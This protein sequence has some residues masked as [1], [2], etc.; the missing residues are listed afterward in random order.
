MGVYRFASALDDMQSKLIDKQGRKSITDIGEIRKFFHNISDIIKKSITPH[1]K[2]DMIYNDIITKSE[3]FEAAKRG[4]NAEHTKPG[5]FSKV[6]RYLHSTSTRSSCATQQPRP[7]KGQLPQ[8]RLAIPD[9]RS[10]ASA[11][12]KESD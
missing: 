4:G 8:N 9:A 1:L 12:T 2:D 11:G 10:T 5:Y 7:D 3:Q 6:T